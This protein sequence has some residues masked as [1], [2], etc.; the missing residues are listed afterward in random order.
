MV[1]NRHTL[2]LCVC[3]GTKY[4]GLLFAHASMRAVVASAK[5]CGQRACLVN[6]RS[7]DRA[8]EN[9]RCTYSRTESLSAAQADVEASLLQGEPRQTPAGRLVSCLAPTPVR[10][11][12]SW[13][14]ALLTLIALQAPQVVQCLPAGLLTIQ[15]CGR[16]QLQLRMQT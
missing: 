11:L 15:V 7:V 4:F 6:R 13:A 5:P 9:M 16:Q 14:P 12:A 3:T 10:F 2:C 1:H 8:R